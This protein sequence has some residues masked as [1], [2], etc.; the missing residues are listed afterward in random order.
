MAKRVMDQAVR[1]SALQWSL[2]GV[3]K[4]LQFFIGSED[5][6]VTPG[7]TI[8]P[9]TLYEAWYQVKLRQQQLVLYSTRST[10][11]FWAHCVTVAQECNLCIFFEGQQQLHMRK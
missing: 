1:A 11:W 3:Q 6:R 7:H 8:L 4:N 10:S 5:P 2:V 9:V